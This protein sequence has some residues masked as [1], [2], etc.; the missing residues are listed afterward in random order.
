M[1]NRLLANSIGPNV[2]HRLALFYRLNVAG[3]F[4]FWCSLYFVKTAFLLLY[5][6]IFQVP[7]T[8]SRVWWMASL[9]VFL[10]FWPR[11]QVHSHSVVALRTPIKHGSSF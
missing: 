1:A 3:V 6:Q 7:Q 5:R 8:F 11:L 9:F 4:M 2:E 10:C